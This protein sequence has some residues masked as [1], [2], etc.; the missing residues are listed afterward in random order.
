MAAGEPAGLDVLDLR[1]G[2]LKQR[3]LTAQE[4]IRAYLAGTVDTI[5]ELDTALLPYS[6]SRGSMVYTPHWDRIATPSVMSPV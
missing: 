1:L 3:V 2:G 4:R 6:P 5:E